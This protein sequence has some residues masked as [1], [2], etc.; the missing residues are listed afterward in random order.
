MT[1]KTAIV[2]RKLSSDEGFQVFED[3]LPHT[4]LQ[5]IR[6]KIGYKGHKFT[7]THKEAKTR[8]EGTQGWVGRHSL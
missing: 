3:E 5:L 4:H 1:V 7:I 8:E 6:G 2:T